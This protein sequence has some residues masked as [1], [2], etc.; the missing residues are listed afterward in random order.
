MT[1][2]Q[3]KRDRN[4]ERKKQ[5]KILT[6]RKREKEVRF[7]NLSIPEKTSRIKR[8][9]IRPKIGIHVYGIQV[10]KDMSILRNQKSC[11]R[12]IT[13]VIKKKKGKEEKGNDQNWIQSLDMD[14][15]Q[16]VPGD[17][18]NADQEVMQE[19]K[20]RKE[21]GKRRSNKNYVI[22]SLPHVC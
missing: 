9:R 14:Q 15:E 3:R 5:D 19:D 16:D 12:S 10:G 11:Q 1:V 2:T 13:V 17:E 18:K 21:T 8:I 20:K 6:D 7:E 22:T 4:R